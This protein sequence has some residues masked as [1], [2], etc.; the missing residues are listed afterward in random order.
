MEALM[1]RKP[2][3]MIC[4]ITRVCEILEPRWT[5]PILVGLWAGASKF[6]EIRREIGSISPA[7]LSRRLRELEDLGMVERIDDKASGSTSYVRTP[8]AIALEPIL[9]GLAHWSQCNIEAETA[10]CT[11]TAS[12]L[13]WK[14]R[15]YFLEDALPRRRIVMQFRFSDADTEYDTYWAV[16]QPGAPAEIC[17]SIPGF[18]VDLFVETSVVALLA[19]LLGRTTIARQI[20]TGGLFLGGDAVLARTM[21]RW[22][23]VSEYADLD[24]I[25]QLAEG[26][27]A[28]TMS[29]LRPVPSV[30]RR[31][32]QARL[33]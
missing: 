10:L 26:P 21:D 22:L 32:A 24:G 3:G 14:M 19:I 16:L 31:V 13:M 1:T 28:R 5:I 2:Y 11:A 4:P 30:S 7:L 20:D 15:N 18:E 12:N 33:A 17:T 27:S 23:K 29:A 6:N 8:K 9:T 25:G